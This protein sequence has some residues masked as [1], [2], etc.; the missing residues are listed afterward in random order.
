MD[1]LPEEVLLHIFS[2]VDCKTLITAVKLIC[3]RFYELLS[4]ENTW[5]FLYPEIGTNKEYY[6]IQDYGTDKVLY[7]KCTER[8]FWGPTNQHI[9]VDY[10][11]GSVGAVDVVRVFDQGRYCLSGSRDKSI[12][13][14]S[15]DEQLRES[16][17]QYYKGSL[18]GHNVWRMY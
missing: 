1:L 15:L 14:W 11:R 2:Y 18:M 4:A 12:N 16:P 7:Y 13:I 5:K 10:L 17:L 8:R 9:S 6:D 3:K